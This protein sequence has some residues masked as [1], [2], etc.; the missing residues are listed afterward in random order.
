MEGFFQEKAAYRALVIGAGGTIGR[1]FAAILEKDKDCI[2]V[3]RISRSINASFDLTNEAGIAQQA[4]NCKPQGPFDLIVDAT[5][6]LTIDGLGPEKSLNALQLEHLTRAFQINAIGPALIIRHFAGLLAPG[7]AIYAKLSARVGSISDN[8]KGGW[9]GYRAAKAALNMIL[10]TAAIELQRKNPQLAV[11]A[12]Q[13]GTVRSPLSQPFASQ[14]ENMLEAADSAQ[15]M[16]QAL[17][18]LAPKAG[19]HF[20]DY[21][22]QTIAW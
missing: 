6:A 20:I 12:L 9:Y 22:G 7:P 11:V 14:V 15:G 1:A 13:P 4:R 19:A 5:G 2:G 8:R 16:L 17:K 10:Q 3:K 18:N 21:R